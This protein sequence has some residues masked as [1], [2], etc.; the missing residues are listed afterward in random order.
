MIGTYPRKATY[1]KKTK[2]LLELDARHISPSYT[3]DY[4]FI[5]AH[6]RDREV[7]DVDDN[8]YLD[9]GAGIASTSTGH[10][11]P[12][13]V[14]AIKKQADRLIHMSGTDFYYEPQIALAHKL[15]EITDNEYMMS[16]FANSGAEAVEAAMKLAKAYTGKVG[17]IAFTGAFHGRT[18]GALSLT[19]SKAIQRSGYLPLQPVV[20]APYPNCYDCWFNAD[21]EQCNNEGCVCIDY[22]DKAILKTVMPP[23]DCAAIVME[24]IQGEGG[25]IVPP[26]FWFRDLEDMA[27]CNGIMTICDEVQAGM[28]RTGRWFASQHWSYEFTPDIITS[29]KGIASGMPLG[30]MMADKDIMS[31]WEP[32]SH[33]STFGGNPVC[34]A[35]ALATI[36]VIER[37]D[38]MDN[39]EKRGFEL[40]DLLRFLRDTS[41]AVANPRGLGLMRAV[42]ILGENKKGN[43][44]DQVLMRCFEK[45]LILLGC[46]KD[47]IRFCPALNVTEEEVKTCVTI[48]ADTISEL[49]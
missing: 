38:L 20:H 37:E 26:D 33:A 11:H 4:P 17:F 41:G 22:I 9:F 31:L 35:A 2:D 3:R 5:V 47:G 49:I 6:G 8:L 21:R 40:G 12:D 18:L 45:G 34:C 36:E 7:R 46:G 32:G 29:A 27:G 14:N 23:E 39:A 42:D 44:R 24:P 43:F 10:C 15:A 16:F 48:L 1:T 13:V 25:Y 28:G 30:V 19:G